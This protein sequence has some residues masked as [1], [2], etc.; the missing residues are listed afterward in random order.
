MIG[1]GHKGRTDANHGQVKALFEAHGIHTHSTAMLGSG[2]PDLLCG[3]RD[4]LCLVEV[5]NGDKPLTEDEIRFHAIWP[6][7]VARDAEDVT[8]ICAWLKR[9]GTDR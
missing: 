8:Q 9:E 5:K 3:I 6:C 2:F 1:R 4:R 7:F